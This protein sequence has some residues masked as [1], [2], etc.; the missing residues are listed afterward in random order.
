V[1]GFYSNFD[2]TGGDFYRNEMLTKYPD[3]NPPVLE[4]SVDKYLKPAE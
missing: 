3:S 2:I 1:E 4:L